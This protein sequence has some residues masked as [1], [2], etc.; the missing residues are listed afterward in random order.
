MLSLSLFPFRFLFSFFPLCI[1]LSAAAKQMSISAKQR[2][3]EGLSVFHKSNKT[4]SDCRKAFFKVCDYIVYMLG[5][6]G[7]TDGRLCDA[8]LRQFPVRKL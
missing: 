4:L 7:K 3:P 5:T 2:V 8:L 1:P 6:D